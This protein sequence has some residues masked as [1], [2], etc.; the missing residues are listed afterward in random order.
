[1][2]GQ[3]TNAYCDQT[4]HIGI[5]RDTTDSAGSTMT[6]LKKKRRSLHILV[7]K[8]LHDEKWSTP[9]VRKKYATNFYISN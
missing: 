9:N 4:S 1:M 8:G 6:S 2:Y 5:Q 7:H 3:K